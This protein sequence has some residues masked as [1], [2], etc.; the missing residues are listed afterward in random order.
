[1]ATRAR[2]RRNFHVP[3]EQAVYEQ[4]RAEAERQSRPATD[5]ARDAIEAWL[6]EQRRLAVHESLA[7]YA[8]A[9]AGTADDLDESL[10][11][12]AVDTLLGDDRR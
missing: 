10:E 12:A 1:M 11:Q 6:R 5:L 3:L 7:A 9:V 4:L 2:S 8:R